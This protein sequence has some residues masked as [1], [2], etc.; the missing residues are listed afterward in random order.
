M[1][2]EADLRIWREDA[3]L[4][5]HHEHWHL[6]YPWNGRD[7]G[8]PFDSRHG[9]LFAYM[10][11][12][13]LARYDAERRS[14][15]LPRVLPYADYR[16]PMLE[17]YDP[18]SLAWFESA[19]STLHTY[20]VRPPGE[21]LHDLTGQFAGRPGALLGD[22]E[23]YRDALRRDASSRIFASLNALSEATESTDDG[24]A[25]L[26]YG[27][28]HNDGHI[29]IS[30]YDSGK[31]YGVLM[32]EAT[33]IRDPI[34]YRWHKHIDDIFELYRVRQTP[35]AFGNL[36][37]LIRSDKDIILC[38]AEDLPG[39]VD[40]HTLGAHC[41]GSASGMSNSWDA[42][43][44]GGQAAMFQG[45]QIRTTNELYTELRNRDFRVL[46]SNGQFAIEN[47]PYLASGGFVYFLRMANQSSFPLRVTIRIFLAP[48]TDAQD[49]RSWI[50]MD[51]FSCDFE[52]EERKV[53]ARPAEFSSVVRKPALTPSVLEPMYRP[54]SNNA[55]HWCD[56]GWP[57][58][59]L[60]PR[61]DEAGMAFQLMVMVSEGDD[62]R[63]G[64]GVDGA[65]SY[66]GIQGG[67]YPDRKPMGY[68]FDRDWAG[69][70]SGTIA[71]HPNMAARP[72]QIR[73][74]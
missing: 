61:G 48:Q 54:S 41:F 15:G 2:S 50:E 12:Q 71:A 32:H 17:G 63:D 3:L 47:I 43:F 34:F 8:K 33:A 6:V 28:L 70:I 73:H 44:S 23:R 65:V 4:N 30:A 26:P 56:C 58:T 14:V 66:C 51:K 7:F 39:N 57:Y 31:N 38:L 45:H 11:E 35:H 46:R 24:N 55:S 18:G 59:L 27:A 62:L 20:G 49:R 10:H 60:L 69:S 13:L 74:H 5:D 67:Q 1:P 42:D 68:P 29:H 9:E 40:L 16:S 64:F 52:S 36:P 21:L 22:M 37:V 72:I 25:P 19:T 53:I